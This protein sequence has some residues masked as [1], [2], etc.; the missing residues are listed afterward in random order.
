MAPFREKQRCSMYTYEM[1]CAESGSVFNH[2]TLKH[3][4]SSPIRA[5]KKIQLN[6]FPKNSVI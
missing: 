3:E 2:L 1:L 5:T 4:G 6:A